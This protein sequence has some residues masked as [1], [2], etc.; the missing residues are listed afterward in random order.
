ME[1][2][3]AWPGVSAGQPVPRQELAKASV[4]LGEHRLFLGLLAYAALSSSNKDPIRRSSSWCSGPRP[5]LRTAPISM[6]STLPPAAELASGL[7][8]TSPDA[9]RFRNQRSPIGLLYSVRAFVICCSLP[10]GEASWA[11]VR[12]PLNTA[13]VSA[14]FER[15]S[16]SGLKKDAYLRRSGCHG[17]MGVQPLIR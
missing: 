6:R 12:F 7:T 8:K 14:G 17:G 11:Y 15:A 10:G 1:R 3:V 2:C 4:P 16:T 5:E 9:L 13:A